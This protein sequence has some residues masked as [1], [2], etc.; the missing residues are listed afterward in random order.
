MSNVQPR[1]DTKTPSMIYN[2]KFSYEIK[3]A[4]NRSPRLYDYGFDVLD[5]AHHRGIQLSP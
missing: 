4:G 2:K 1:A 3:R 5:L